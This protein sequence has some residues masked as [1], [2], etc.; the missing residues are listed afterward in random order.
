MLEGDSPCNRRV[1]N[2][3][4]CRVPNRFHQ[5]LGIDERTG[6][7]LR[8]ERTGESEVRLTRGKISDRE[9]E[10]SR[11]TP[12]GTIKSGT[13][14]AAEKF[15][16]ECVMEV[17]RGRT[18]VKAMQDEYRA[19]LGMHPSEDDRPSDVYMG[20]ALRQRHPEAK[21]SARIGD[22]GQLI[23]VYKNV[24]IVTVYA[25]RARKRKEQKE[26]E[27]LDGLLETDEEI[28][29]EDFEEGEIYSGGGKEEQ[30]NGSEKN[31]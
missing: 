10:G 22:Q 1:G 24:G 28:R 26:Q 30:E 27:G 3:G 4:I 13:V 2:R 6:G 14:V 25:E 9:K 20:R 7:V 19:W 11:R 5:M 21:R 16:E 31:S 8:W 18:D 23:P 29:Q 15:V 17:T 12:S